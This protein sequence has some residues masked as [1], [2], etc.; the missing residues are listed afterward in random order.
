MYRIKMK[1]EEGLKMSVADTKT[2]R[3]L[4]HWA[5]GAHKGPRGR[6]GKIKVS[7]YISIAEGIRY[8]RCKEH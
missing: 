7:L 5:S 3:T 2:T 4:Q 8:Q 6:Q 1:N